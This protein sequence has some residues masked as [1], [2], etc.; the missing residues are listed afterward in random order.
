VLKSIPG[1]RSLTIG[2]VHSTQH[3]ENDV[4]KRITQ[5]IDLATKES[6]DGQ[7]M[8]ARDFDS[9]RLLVA[10]TI[11]AFASVSTGRLL[12]H[13]TEFVHEI[14]TLGSKA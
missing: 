9:G 10:P 6:P 8:A 11:F 13:A 3:V 14:E 2:N 1:R 7:N 4:L 5:K 12:F